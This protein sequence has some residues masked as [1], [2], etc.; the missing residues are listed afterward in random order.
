MR[1]RTK[2]MLVAVPALIA[3]VFAAGMGGPSSSPDE[4]KTGDRVTFSGTM[5]YQEWTRDGR[6]GEI[7][8]DSGERVRFIHPSGDFLAAPGMGIT[9]TGEVLESGVVRVEDARW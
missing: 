9:I 7:E 6:V 4:W 5:I 1:G 2:V 8:T 3:V